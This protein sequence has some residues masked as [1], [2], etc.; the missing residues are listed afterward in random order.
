MVAFSLGFSY[1]VD[2]NN[3]HPDRQPQ[4]E[5]ALMCLNMASLVSS[6]RQSFEVAFPDR[7]DTQAHIIAIMQKVLNDEFKKESAT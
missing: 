4:A 3:I 7:K 6:M 5:F 2:M 1:I